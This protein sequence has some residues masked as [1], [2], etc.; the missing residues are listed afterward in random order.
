[1]ADINNPASRL[2]QLLV[3]LNAANHNES[4]SLVLSR[5][6]GVSSDPLPLMHALVG[7]QELAEE[8]VKWTSRSN[9]P[10]APIE[11][12]IPQIKSIVAITNLDAPWASYKARITSDCLVVIEMVAHASGLSQEEP[13]AIESMVELS[14][15]IDELFRTVEQTKELDVELRT[16]ILGQLELIRRVISEYRISGAK[17]FSSYIEKLLFEAAKK[18]EVLKKAQESKSS[19]FEKFRGLVVKLGGYAKRATEDFEAIE[20]VA[21]AGKNLLELLP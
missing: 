14:A 20:N 3:A 17:G 7:F 2:H 19:V 8:V 18:S 5:V 1:M 9:L 11:R 12:Y 13:I 10:L 21:K 16:F 4:T 6:F 15:E